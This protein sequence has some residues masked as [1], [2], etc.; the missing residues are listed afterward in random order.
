ME[1]GEKSKECCERLEVKDKVYA[2]QKDCHS[3]VK[4]L[5]ADE[6]RG[7][8]KGVQLRD[9]AD[10]V[11]VIHPRRQILN[12]GGKGVNKDSVWLDPYFTD[13]PDDHP[14]AKFKDSYVVEW[15]LTGVTLVLARGFTLDPTTG[16]E[17]SVYAVQEIKTN[18]ERKRPIKPKPARSRDG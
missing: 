2:H 5:D 1:N 9:W 10:T 12:V 16:N 15:V 4:D 3:Y 7:I 17:M 6:L 18:D 8:L 11:L 14:H 13:L